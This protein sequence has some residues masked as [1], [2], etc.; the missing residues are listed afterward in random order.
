[1]IRGI[2]FTNLDNYHNVK[3]P[4]R[5]AVVPAIG[6]YVGANSGVSLKVVAITHVNI[7]T[8]NPHDPIMIKIELH[9]Q[10]H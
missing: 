6:S 8:E 7:E 2:C 5:F 9:K 10:S 1:M 3:W 4:I